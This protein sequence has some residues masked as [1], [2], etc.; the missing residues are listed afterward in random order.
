MCIRDRIIGG[1][2]EPVSRLQELLPRTLRERL[3]GTFETEMFASNSETLDRASAVL[4]A[5]ERESEERVVAQLREGAHDGGAAV[6]GFT[7]TLAAVAARQARACPLYTSP[8][9]R[10]RPRHRMPSSA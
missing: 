5:A 1:P 9:P 6:L 7:P 3:A 10:D 2:V 8:S 4:K